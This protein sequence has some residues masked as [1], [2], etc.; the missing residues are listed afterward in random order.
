MARPR[1]DAFTHAVS[2]LAKRERTREG[3]HAALIAKGHGEAEVDAALAR[4]AQLGY[5]DDA[6]VAQAQARRELATGRSRADVARRLVRHGIA[7]DVAR[8]ATSAAAEE[9]GHDDEAAARE[10]VRKRGLEGVKAARFLAARGFDEA[11]VRR[12]TGVEES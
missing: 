11:I 1:P 10:L 9:T 8:T 4:V 7:E 5:L 2:L 6:K 3:L 12:I